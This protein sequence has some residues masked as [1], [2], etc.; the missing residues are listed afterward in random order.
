MCWDGINF[1][2]NSEVKNVQRSRLGFTLVTGPLKPGAK[3]TLK[4]HVQAPVVARQRPG[5]LS[6]LVWKEEGARAKWLRK[7]PSRQWTPG[8]SLPGLW[9]AVDLRFSPASW[10]VSATQLMQGLPPWSKSCKRFPCFMLPAQPSVHSG[11]HG[12]GR[13]TSILPLIW[14]R[15]RWFREAGPAGKVA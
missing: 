8:P 2:F 7:R 10:L 9:A 11:A 4:K 6:F 13:Q 12:H 1:T 14:M 15:R 5:A 3:Q